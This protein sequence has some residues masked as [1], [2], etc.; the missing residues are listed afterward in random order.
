MVEGFSTDTVST[1]VI[2]LARAAE[3]LGL[4]E[5][6]DQGLWRYFWGLRRNKGGKPLEKGGAQVKNMEGMLKTK[7]KECALASL[8]IPVKPV[9]IPSKIWEAPPAQQRSAPLHT[10]RTQSGFSA[11]YDYGD[12][13]VQ[14]RPGHN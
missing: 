13:I 7:L 11:I 3:L 6:Q 9:S 14:V 12:K 1:A 4:G 2:P 8:K 5:S 10:A